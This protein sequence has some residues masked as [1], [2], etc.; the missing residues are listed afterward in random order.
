MRPSAAPTAAHP[1]PGH[2][3]CPRPS[4]PI[5]P[6]RRR[7]SCVV[8]VVLEK[9]TLKHPGSCVL[10]IPMSCRVVTADAAWQPRR[11][12]RTLGR[13]A[14]RGVR[15]ALRYGTRARGAHFLVPGERRTFTPK[16]EKSSLL[17]RRSPDPRTASGVPPGA[18]HLIAPPTS[19][20]STWRLEPRGAA[21][22]ARG[23]GERRGVQALVGGQIGSCWHS[24]PPVPDKAR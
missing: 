23:H 16:N 6:F 20:G 18:P 21:V 4:S 14:C 8:V 10:F 12:P 19:A 11:R 2:D 24:A 5:A 22:E 7:S 13:G 17:I 3:T 1:I 9:T 15:G